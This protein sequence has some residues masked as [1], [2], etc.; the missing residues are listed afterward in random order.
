[1]VGGA[2]P[3]PQ[4]LNTE[5]SLIGAHPNMHPCTKADSLLHVAH[6]P[7]RVPKPRFIADPKLHPKSAQ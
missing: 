2:L 6:F 1:M 4:T 5:C 7:V 3:K